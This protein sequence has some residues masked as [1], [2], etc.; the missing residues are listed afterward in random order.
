VIEKNLFIRNN[1]KIK[2]LQGKISKKFEKILQDIKNDIENNHKTLNVL[3]KNFEFSFNFK[4]LNKF[5]KFKTLA[6][7]GM[8][9][10]ILGSEALYNFFQKK[11]KKKA[12][13]LN[14]LDENQ[15]LKL[16][17]NENLSKVLFIIISKSGNT[18]ETLSNVFSL[19][20]IKKN[21]K[22]IILISEKKDNHLYFLSKKLNLFY[23]EHKNYIGGRYSVLSEVGI[24]PAYLMGL[25]INSLRLSIRNCLKDKN[26]VFLKNSTIKLSKI[27]QSKKFNNL[28]LLNYAPELEKFLFW[29]QQLIAESLGKKNKGFLPVISNSPKDHHSLLQLYLDGPKDKIF[30]IFS[31][32]KKSNISIYLNKNY[33]IKSFLNKKNF[34]Q[35]K[36]A[37]KN[38]LIKS[39]KY[40]NIPFREFKIKDFKEETLGELFS[41]FIVETIIIGKLIG[42]N[43]FDQPAVEQVKIN[44]QKLLS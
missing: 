24:I 17:K 38:A 26:K 22:N 34:N 1:I 4:D 25:N 20:V 2:N 16:K 13:F 23:I 7:I 31:L 30:Y 37:Q 9:G 35:V 32:V 42:I 11:I 3:S 40:K 14:D 5:K 28:I 44:T 21:S 8:G 27:I 41:Y 6:F 39:L 29:Y 18:I 10:S 36:N 43:P 19:N 33:G 15:V 12:Y